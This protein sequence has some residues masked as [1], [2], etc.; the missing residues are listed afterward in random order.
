MPDV[1][2]FRRP[3]QR[4]QLA[5][6]VKLVSERMSHLRSVSAGVWIARGSRHEAEHESGISH[7]VEHMMF[8]G[9]PRR[10]SLEI[11]RTVDSLGGHIDAFTSKEH[12]CF[13]TK[14]LDEHFPAAFQLLGD[15]V[16]DPAFRDE[17]I[18]REKRVVLEE[19]KM[20]AD[21][22]EHQVFNMF[23]RAFWRGHPLGRSILGSETTVRSY[24]REALSSFYQRTY[25]PENIVIS[26]AGNVDH[27]ALHRVVEQRFGGLPRGAPREMEIAPLT[28][29]L[30]EWK[31]RESLEQ[32]HLCI[33]F[34]SVSYA[35]EDRY[36]CYVLNALLGG[37]LSSRLFQNVREKH[38]LAYNVFSELSPYSDSGCLSI[39][40]A[41]APATARALL[42]AVLGELRRLKCEEV[43]SS[44]LER[45]KR[46]LKGSLMLSLE[47]S[48]SRMAHLARQEMFLGQPMELDTLIERVDR[49]SVEDIRRV[50]VALFRGEAM[51][52]AGIGG[53]VPQEFAREELQL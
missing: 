16:L 40:A 37:G 9:T 25:R 50:A 46:Y 26:A 2:S 45:S 28:H 13:N 42:E 51:G 53:T 47:S 30:M 14:V 43:A 48:S 1:S 39:Y 31:S 44:E 24:S 22:P 19:I 10:D 35:H 17:D 12:A 33:G 18:Q 36:I 20:E 34:P 21:S 32:V 27:D 52:L 5:N 11:A 29:P 23:A 41:T 49:V 38:G 7:F 4:S 15:L 6:G 3:I 8:K